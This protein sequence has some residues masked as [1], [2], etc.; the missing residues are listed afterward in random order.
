MTCYM[1]DDEIRENTPESVLLYVELCTK[2]DT[3]INSSN[4]IGEVTE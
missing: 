1:C 2:C 3:E 4:Y